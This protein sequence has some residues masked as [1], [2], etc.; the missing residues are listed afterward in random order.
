MSRTNVR[1]RKALLEYL[2]DHSPVI[3]PSMLKCDF[4]NLKREIEQ[5]ESA[6]A[7]V[8]HWDVMD[9]HFV[10]NMTYGPPLIEQWR[11]ITDLPFDAHLMISN[12]EESLDE[13]LEAGCDMITV[14]IEAI[15]HPAN[16]L[17]KIRDADRVAGISLNPETGVEEIEPYLDLCDMVLV[18]SVHPGFGGQKF[19]LGSLD[20]LKALRKMKG[21]EIILSIDGGVGETTI[22][23]ATQSGATFFVV[24]SAIFENSDY[25]RSIEHLSELAQNSIAL[26]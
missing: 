4:A 11:E 6:D 25:K 24:G 15:P 16:I 23:E 21:T 9:G 1:S 13:Y 14:H 8:L 22:S 10:P 3:A 18:M 7:A 19:L 2:R 17:K 26:S 20:K 12:P 5:L